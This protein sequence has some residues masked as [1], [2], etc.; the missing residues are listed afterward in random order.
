MD[1]GWDV[2]VVGAGAVGNY[3]S[4]KLAGWG[5]KVLVLEEHPRLGEPVC[6]SGILGRECLEAFPTKPDIIL[7]ELRSATFFSP[8]GK[9]LRVVSSRPQ[10]YLVNRAEYDRHLA[11]CALGQGVEFRLGAKVQEIEVARGVKLRVETEEGSAWVAGRMLVLAPGFPTTLTRGLGEI[12][13]WAVAGQVEVSTR[14][15]EEV[16]IYLGQRRAPGFFAW[17]A[18]TRAGRGL[19]GVMSAYPGP[20]LPRFLAE[21]VVADKIEPPQDTMCFRRLPVAPLSHT[22]GERIVV[23]GEAAG[24]VKVTTG[25]GIYYGLLCAE[26]AARTIK[27]AFDQG[28]FSPAFIQRYEQEWRKLLAGELRWG[29]W[30]R[31]VYAHLS[32]PQMEQ[33]FN[34]ARSSHI[35]SSI[36]EADGFSFDWHSRAISE[37]PRLCRGQAFRGLRSLFAL[38]LGFKEN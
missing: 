24:Q 10:A 33:L 7:R 20:F 25:G 14:G 31:K 27:A 28:D 38:P 29:G 35:L 2:L 36:V 11:R 32:D 34:L 8:S 4:G 16:E 5:L 18:P 3:I 1:S 19:A 30:A 6:C 15:V 12:A 17:L 37:I 23:V 22:C 26:I 21:L 9:M 13:A